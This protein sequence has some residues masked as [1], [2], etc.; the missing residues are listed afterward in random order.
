MYVVYWKRSLHRTPRDTSWP[1]LSNRTTKI[2][3]IIKGGMDEIVPYMD[4]VVEDNIKQNL[5]EW[6]ICYTN[7]NVNPKKIT[8]TVLRHSNDDKDSMM[9]HYVAV[10]AD[11]LN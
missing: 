7:A 10:E 9:L 3:G 6:H 11:Y 8:F 1:T 2:V 5:N 4:S